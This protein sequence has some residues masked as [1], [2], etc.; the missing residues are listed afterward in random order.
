MRKTLLNVARQAL[1]MGLL[2][3]PAPFLMGAAAPTHAATTAEADLMHTP[4]GQTT[5][6]WNP[7]THVLRVVVVLSGLAPKSTHPAH[8]HVGSCAVDA[9]VLYMLYPVV[10]DAAGNGGSTTIINGVTGGIPASGWSINVHNGPGLTKSS[11]APKNQYLPLACGD[12][13]NGDTNR[14]HTQAIRA[15]LHATF[16]VDQ[17]AVGSSE[18]W[19]TNNTLYVRVTALNLQPGSTH[20]AHVHYG[21]CA[22]QG[23]IAYNLVDLKANSMGVATSTTAIRGV[24]AIPDHGW[25]INIHLGVGNDLKTQTGFDPILCGNVTVN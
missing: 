19:I 3:V 11:Y 10:A 16:G 1:F 2:L 7:Q 4:K 24:N 20:M 8:I 17:S 9:P 14:T 15:T 22:S 5:L 12:L 6:N 23:G 21:S 13:V 25:Y 18:L